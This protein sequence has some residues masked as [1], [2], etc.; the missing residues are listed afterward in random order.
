MDAE[1]NFLIIIFSIIYFSPIWIVFLRK[2]I[3]KKKVV[4]INLLS[5]LFIM[6]WPI[7]FLGWIVSLFLS[8]SGKTQKDLIKEE[9]DYKRRSKERS[10]IS[11]EAEKN[12]KKKEAE[13]KKYRR[14][15]KISIKK[16]VDRNISEIARAHRTLIKK[17]SFGKRDDQKFREELWEFMQDQKEIQEFFSDE[18]L[19]L[20]IEIYNETIIDHIEKRIHSLNLTSDYSEEMDPF[21]YESYC[22]NQFIKNGWDASA[23]QGTSDQGVDVIAKK[24]GIVLV[25]QCKKYSKPVGNKAVQEIVAGIK[26]YNANRGLVITNSS[27]TESAKKLASANDIKLLH[28]TEIKDIY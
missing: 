22:A 9:E 20:F 16:T 13:I 12:R 23:T 24:D 28:H 25:A 19:D 17:N 14:E 11:R 4:I 21:E 3:R 1:N 27:F 26:F 6:A 5:L 2:N 15:I 10:R 8:L 7:L 18:N